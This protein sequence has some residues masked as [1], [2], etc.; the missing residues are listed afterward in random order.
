MH[1]K[2]FLDANILFTAALSD[3]GASRYLFRIAEV[4]PTLHLITSPYALEEAR[5][6][7]TKKYNVATAAFSALVT[8]SVL[9]ISLDPPRTLVI[10]AENV[11]IKKDAP[12]LA[13]ALSSKADILCTLD[14]KDFFTNNVLTWTKK[15]DT[16]VALPG[17]V[18]Q[19]WKKQQESK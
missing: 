9:T 2:I 1:M 11:I 6:N 10:H 5:I 19:E 3:T 17:P 12:I 4:D 7:I 15:Y 8:S 13:G 18:V 16:R 14:K